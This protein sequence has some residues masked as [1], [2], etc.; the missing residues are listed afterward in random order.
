MKMHMTLFDK[1]VERISHA[2]VWMKYSNRVWQAQGRGSFDTE[3]QR[4]VLHNWRHLKCSQA[5]VMHAWKE[6]D[7]A[8]ISSLLFNVVDV[9]VS[10]AHCRKI[11]WILSLRVNRW[12]YVPVLTQRKHTSVVWMLT[13]ISLRVFSVHVCVHVRRESKHCSSY[14]ALSDTVLAEAWSGYA[15]HRQQP[16][17]PFVVTL[18][19]GSNTMLPQ[20][21]DT[22]F[23]PCL[24]LWWCIHNAGQE[25]TTGTHRPRKQ[26]S[27]PSEFIAWV[28][29]IPWDG[30]N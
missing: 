7:L 17:N 1:S 29:S 10:H 27:L 13:H 4:L 19:T 20:H 25:S 26:S 15:D 23:I 2:T 6:P 3:K 18:Q 14:S 5:T 21:G 28:W 22:A 8:W 24:N 9:H 16:V 12:I 11:A 30:C